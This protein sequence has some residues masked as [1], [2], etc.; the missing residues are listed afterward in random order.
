MARDP[1]PR[2]RAWLIENGHATEAE[3]AAIEAGIER[4]ID[5]AVEF[6]LD[7]RRTRTSPNCAATSLPRR[8]THER[9][10]AKPSR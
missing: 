8:C 3:L 9:T 7:E 6:A 2:F 1:V 5:E 10:A 4:E